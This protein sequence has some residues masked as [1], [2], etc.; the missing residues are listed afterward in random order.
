MQDQVQLVEVN[1]IFEQRIAVAGD[2]NKEFVFEVLGH[3][4]VF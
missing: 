4:R 3:L 1:L 2:L